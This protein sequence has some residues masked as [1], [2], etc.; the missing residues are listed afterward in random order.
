VWDNNPA[1]QPIVD[2]YVTL[3]KY[4]KLELQPGPLHEARKAMMADVPAFQ[5][6]S[7]GEWRWSRAYDY[8]H[9]RISHNLPLHGAVTREHAEAVSDFLAFR[10]NGWFSDHRIVSMAGMPFV[11]RFATACFDML[12]KPTAGAAPR[13]AI[14]G[15]HD[16]SVLPV[17]HALT[18]PEEREGLAWPPYA[19]ELRLELW[20]GHLEEG[21]VVELHMDGDKRSI[22]GG[23]RRGRAMDAGNPYL[24][25]GVVEAMGLQ[26]D[27]EAHAN[28]VKKW[29]KT[30]CY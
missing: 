20:E 6:V 4:R 11:K 18:A 24:P 2:E 19:S 1:I 5:D 27:Q 25:G 3:A 28:A 8:V 26:E 22:R 9:T 21:L 10:A 17:L 16:I 29:L 14:S 15:G 30:A 23:D 12:A 7:L 13:I